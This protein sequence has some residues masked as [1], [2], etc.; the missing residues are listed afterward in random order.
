MNGSRGLDALKSRGLDSILMDIT[1]RQAKEA[2]GI[3]T[4]A[5]LARFFG[6]LRQAVAQW[7]EDEPLPQARQWEL[8]A[9]R[10]RLFP[11]PG[12]AA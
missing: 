10:P 11:K 7:K 2:L 8:R 6:I 5:G 12:K 1:K 3:E 4:D 9:K